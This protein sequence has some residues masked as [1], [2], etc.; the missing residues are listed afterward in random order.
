MLHS[1][2]PHDRPF[3]VSAQISTAPLG[4]ICEVELWKAVRWS[5]DD[6]L[7]D[8]GIWDDV[9]GFWSDGD[10]AD[11][12]ERQRKGSQ[13]RGPKREGASRTAGRLKSRHDV[14]VSYNASS[15][16]TLPPCRLAMPSWGSTGS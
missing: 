15:R 5:D 14:L 8:E 16:V 6:D 13:G 11:Y 2:Q 12:S 7:D 1:S 10:D 9:K 4:P 3:P